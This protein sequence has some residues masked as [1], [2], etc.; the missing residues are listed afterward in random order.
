MECFQLSTQELAAM[1]ADGW[2]IVSG[3]HDTEDQCANACGHGISENED[4]AT[5]ADNSQT[6]FCFAN[7]FTSGNVMLNGL[8]QREG[9]TNDYTVVDG[10][11][12]F[13]VAPLTGDVITASYSY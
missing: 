8:A 6:T 13:N 12:V 11:V 1:Q 9:A 7:T 2:T 10:C 5:P 3:P 4:S